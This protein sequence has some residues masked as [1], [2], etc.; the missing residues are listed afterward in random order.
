LFDSTGLADVVL[1]AGTFVVVLLV[2]G[3]IT[4][5]VSDLILDSRVGALDR[6][7][8]FV[9]GFARGVVLVAVAFLFV[10]WLLPPDKQPSWVRD[11]QT[12]PYMETAGAFIRSLLPED[13]SDIIDRLPGGLGNIGRGSG[14]DSSPP[15]EPPGEAPSDGDADPSSGT[16]P[17]GGGA[18]GDL[19]DARLTADDIQPA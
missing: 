15:D 10:T 12:R 14:E 6:T 17:D 5:R 13:P 4:G 16:A 2:I 11:A 18:G 3:F 1:V 7:L 19:E 8:G 9:F